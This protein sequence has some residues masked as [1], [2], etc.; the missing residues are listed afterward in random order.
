MEEYAPRLRLNG[1]AFFLNIFEQAEFGR[2]YYNIASLL[3]EKF[4]LHAPHRFEF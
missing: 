1:W 2:S 4:R 3:L